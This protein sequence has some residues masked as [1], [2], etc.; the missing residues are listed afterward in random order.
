MVMVGMAVSVTDRFASAARVF[1]AAV[2][3]AVP[4]VVVMLL[5]LLAAATIAGFTGGFGIRSIAATSVRFGGRALSEKLL[6]AMFAAKVEHL[7]VTFC[8]QGGRFIH[9]HAADGVG[10]HNDVRFS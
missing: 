4:C 1:F 2:L 9:R 5:L 6:P 7:S 8:V 3:V 10:L